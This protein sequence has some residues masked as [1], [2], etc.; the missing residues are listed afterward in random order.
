MNRSVIGWV[1]IG[2]VAVVGAM[3][4]IPAPDTGESIEDSVREKHVSPKLEKVS[5]VRG[6]AKTTSLHSEVKPSEP[7]A[8]KPLARP[9]GAAIRPV[10]SFFQAKMVERHRGKE[11]LSAVFRAVYAIKDDAAQKYA[12]RID[13]LSQLLQKDGTA[14]LQDQQSKLMAELRASEFAKNTEVRAAL[15]LVRDTM[16]DAK[17]TEQLKKKH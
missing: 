7:K 15:D 1:G 5:G 2:V 9:R 10:V 4:L 16:E 17:K 11:P 12:W 14:E 6:T 8:L 3:L 13:E